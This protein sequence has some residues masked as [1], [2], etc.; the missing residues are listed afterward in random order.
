MTTQPY[1]AFILATH[2]QD[3]FSNALVNDL[4]IYTTTPR[5]LVGQGGQ[6]SMVVS[7]DSIAIT[8]CNFIASN[9]Q[10]PNIN[11]QW[12]R[13]SNMN[14]PGYATISNVNTQWLGTSNMNVPGYAT[15]SNVNTQL[16]GASNMNV[17]GYATI[18]NV[19]TQW[20]GASNMNVK[21]YATIS[22]VNTQLL[23]ASNMIVDGYATLS[24]IYSSNATLSN[25]IL[26]GAIWSQYY[27]DSGGC[28][29]SYNI[30]LQTV[31][32]VK[33]IATNEFTI[34]T[35]TQNGTSNVSGELV[36]TYGIINNS[37]YP[38]MA[39]DELV[40]DT[41]VTI[42][43]N[44]QAS[45]SIMT[46]DPKLLG[47]VLVNGRLVLNG[48]DINYDF[49]TTNLNIAG[50]A[51][52]SNINTQW[53]GASNMN[54]K[55]YATTSNLSTEWLETSNM[56]VQGYAT[57]S[58]LSTEWL[59]ASNINV[60]GYTTTTNINTQLLEASNV[61]VKGYVTT[62]NLNTRWLEASNIYS[63]N[64]TFSNILLKG[65]IWSYYSTDNVS[66]FSSNITLE[67]VQTVKCISTKEFTINTTTKNG[68]SNI[69]NELVI[70]YGIVSSSN[71]PYL[72]TDELVIDTGVTT[73][74]NILASSSIMTSDPKLLGSVLVNGRL[75][76]N[77]IDINSEFSTTNLN[78]SY[79]TISNI[80]TQ[81][82]GTTN[83][84]VENYATIS[85]ITTQ[86]LGTSNMNVK[87]YA[88]ASNISTQWL[89]ASNM[90]VQD[91][92][93]MSNLN[94]QW[95]GASN[96]N[97]KGYA[98]ISNIS[99]QLLEASNI[100]VKGYTS[101]SNV[102][103]TGPIWSQYYTDGCSKLSSNITIQTIQ[104]INT[105]STKEFII[106]TSKQN[107]TSNVSRELVITYGG[108]YNSNVVYL[109]TNE[110]I[111]DSGVSVGANIDASSSIV[112]SD[113]KLLGNVSV[114]GKMI[115]NGVD[116]NSEFS[117]N[118]LNITSYATM[119]NVNTQW[120][121]A[122]NVNVR[123]YATMSN[124]NTQWLAA[125]NMNVKGYSTMSNVNTQWLGASNMNVEG[126]VMLSNLVL[127]GPICTQYFTDGDSKSTSNITL[128]TVQTINNL[129]TK[130]FII[131]KVTKNG[132]SN[133]SL[134]LVITY[135]NVYNSN[136]LYM[137]TE[138]LVIDTGVTIGANIEA[139]SSI[140][141]SNPKL[142][143]D[144]LVLGKF[145]LNDI[146]INSNFSTIGLNVAGYASLS[147]INTQWLGAS[148]MNVD[149]YATL[150]NINTQWLGASNMNVKGY[151]T[152]SN[153]NTQWL[154]ASNMNVKG[155]S[156]LSNVSL[157]GSIWSEYCIDGTNFNSNLI[158][159]TVETIHNISTKEFIIDT[160]TKKGTSN[161]SSEL[162]ITYGTIYNSNVMY[163]ATD[164]LVIDSGVTIGANIEASSSI[165]TSDPKL[166][167][168]VL[169]NGKIILNRIDI[170]SNFTT[171]NLNVNYATISNVATQW[172]EGLNMNV[173]NLATL[174]NI[175]TQWLRASNINT[176]W[177]GASNMNVPGLA[178]L[179]NINT[180]WLQASN[181]IGGFATMSNINAQWLQASNI[182][183]SNAT[184][185]NIL[186][187][188][189]IWSY[190]STDGANNFSSNITLQTVQNIKSISTNEFT[191]NTITKNG[192]SNISNE[193]VITYG[194]VSSSNVPY[195][196]MDELVIDTGVTI[197]AN[198]KA[199]SSIVTSDP[200]LLGSVLVNGRIVLNDIDI[201]T[202]FSTTNLNVSYG[203]ISNINT[204]W[205]GAS[206]INVTG[207]A[208]LSNITTQ[209]L[210]ASNMNVQGYAALANVN[211]QL[212][213]AS[214]MF[215][216]NYAT[217]SNIVLKGSIW[218]QYVTNGT[219]NFSS[220]IILQ[221][222]QTVRSITT[223]DFTIDTRT[224]NGT[225]NISRE[226]VITY[227]TV[228]TSNVAYLATDELIIDTGVTIGNIQAS[229]SIITTDPNFNGSVLVNG[230][231][232][233]NGI[234]I[235]SQ[236]S[237]NNLTINDTLNIGNVTQTMSLG[238]GRAPEYQLDMSTDNARKLTSTVWLTGSDQR[239]KTN[240]ED[241]DIDIC[242]SNIQNI[243]LRRFSWNSNV[244]NYKDIEDKTVIGWIAQEVQQY[245]PKSI[246]IS[247]EKG[248]DDFMNLNSD[249]LFKCTYGAL[250][251]AIINIDKL[252]SHMFSMQSQILDMQSQILDMQSRN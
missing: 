105:I 12:L 236:F 172:L 46:S 19:N 98:T 107:G 41:G 230:R 149:G 210:G 157:R 109:A 243:K 160:S 229:S 53:L 123:G 122:S 111:I 180:Q 232:V 156:T 128:Q 240:I 5:I 31:Q 94:T 250:Q 195:L 117:T 79:A 126:Y 27:T 183:S 127:K 151:A 80:T 18:S 225:S 242:Y 152:L 89:G 173:S 42:G 43:A 114:N 108:V 40:I 135:G 58:N 20:L 231:L 99:T 177:L 224:N 133:V 6:C 139:T 106:D 110:L 162:V 52:L 169:V 176:Q 233:L 159:E 186:L 197:G 48:T 188:G 136:P 202:N 164:E 165:V 21:G 191:I 76:L 140:V 184:L 144:V 73:G 54:V 131:D 88:N 59:G 120:L 138:E 17:P 55:G 62:L 222:V 4:L 119:S 49:S 211:T 129:S 83:I 90:N 200:K 66:N 71:V 198:I 193:L 10:I 9:A 226:L 163:L 7:S 60:K 13:A 213:G 16:L 85:N 170:N 179:S 84:N 64:A 218:N 247:S 132:K 237:T 63:S 249:Q 2:N 192:T 203:T 86:W 219:S 116:V 56:N 24:N 8:S 14:V 227:G 82:L 78:V 26:K 124:I 248:I 207:Y 130:E 147:N 187:K 252:Q 204:Q 223:K 216:E 205:L 245:Y 67:T 75:I 47:S 96:M 65:A 134:E 72:A 1:S 28:N 141:T 91:Y 81:L 251:K 167:G 30:T 238:L 37:N 182:Y 104:T 166:L 215:V 235:N 34:D 145:M 61:N 154:G 32:T 69:S 171:T 100:N 178:T 45:S 153:I 146:D 168:D 44:I 57:T 148:N 70:T 194:I 221:T 239:A 50:N 29:L 220:N 190:Y 244:Y 212:L 143:G 228:S 101:L 217:L 39:T 201:N 77:D 74:V 112:T 181:V 68:T 92:A 115:L 185:S 158:L 206:N 103:L 93:T 196:A 95:L 121:G 23:K 208:T 246:H 125:S 113:P 33:S 97:V 36:I 175:N 3:T 22:N 142:L 11:T 102:L 137:A 189:G 214:N 161:V 150:S 118:N 155:Y 199:T 15:I 35:S 87:G 51:Y 25:I 209:W 241:A 174:S 234:D 38:Y